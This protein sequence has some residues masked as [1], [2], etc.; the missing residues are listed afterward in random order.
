MAI[1]IWHFKKGK[2]GAIQIIRERIWAMYVFK[3]EHK[4]EEEH[5]VELLHIVHIFLK[6]YINQQ[7]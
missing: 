6:M 1:E 2:Q 4:W 5:T 7:V 3:Y